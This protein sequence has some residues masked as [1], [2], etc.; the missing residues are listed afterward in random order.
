MKSY[1]L[2][3]DN[4]VKELKKIVKKSINRVFVLTDFVT[5]QDDSIDLYY[6]KNCAISIT[7]NHTDFNK[8]LDILKNEKIC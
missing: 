8:I 7:K 2:L 1:L 6:T 3:S 4:S 5:K